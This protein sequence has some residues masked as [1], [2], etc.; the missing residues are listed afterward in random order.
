[1]SEIAKC[2]LSNDELVTAVQEWVSKLCDTGG[3]AWTLRVPVD[4]DRDPDILITE[5]CQRFAALEA[6]HAALREAVAW[7]RECGNAEAR[8]SIP[9]ISTIK[10]GS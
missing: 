6:R 9:L 1:M 2:Q 8:G 7:E 4:F 10:T 3:R 5:L